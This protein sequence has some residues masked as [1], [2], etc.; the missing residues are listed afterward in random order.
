[1][2]LLEEDEEVRQ[3]ITDPPTTRSHSLPAALQVLCAL[4]TVDKQR[5]I[6]EGFFD[7]ERFRIPNVIGLV[8]GSLIGIKTPSKDEETFVSRKKGHAINVQ[9]ICDHEMKFINLVVKWPGSTHDAFLWNNCSLNEDFENGNI[10]DGLVLGDS[11]YPL[12]PWLLTPILNPTNDA[13]ESFNVHHRRMRRIIDCCFGKWKMRWLCLHKYGGL[14][15]VK[16][17]TCVNVISATAVLHNICEQ[18][19]VPMPVDAPP[20][21]DDN[22]EEDVNPPNPNFMREDGVQARNHIVQQYIVLCSW[23]GL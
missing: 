16:L 11:A 18:H 15:R 12:R 23:P 14:L 22:P 2:A 4:R 5:P 7:E 21:E 3:H 1:M 6:K 8:D 19:G 17:E 20:N 10:D 13:E 9:G